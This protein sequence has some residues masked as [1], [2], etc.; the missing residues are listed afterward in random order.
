MK[1]ATRIIVPF[2]LII[3]VVISIGWYL[4]K[5]DPEFTKDFLLNQARL[6]EE[7][8]NHGLATWIYN[9]TYRQSNEDENVAIELAE[10][11]KSM[12]NYTKAEYTLSNAIADGGTAQLYIA[13]CNTYVEQDKLLDAVTMLDNIADPQIK[14]QLDEIRPSAPVAT[15]ESGYFNQYINV[16]IDATEGTVYI[17]TTGEYP[18]SKA[19]P[20][21]NDLTLS[22]G[23]T[24][25]YALCIGDNGLVSPLS[26]F[27]YTIAGVIE[28]VSLNDAAMDQLV[29]QQLGVNDEH[30]LYSNELWGI[31]SLD[32]TNEIK[33]L[34][35]LSLMP[36]LEQMTISS[37]SY[38]NLNSLSTLSS[39]HTLRIEGVTL[40][41]D[42]VKT[43]AAL[44]KLQT[45]SLPHCNLSSIADLSVATGLVSLDLSNNTLRDL[46]PLQNLTELKSLQISHNAVTQLSDIC[47]LSK[48]EELDVSYNSL[49]STADLAA[50]TGLKVLRLGHNTLTQLDGLEKLSGLSIIS[51]EGNKLTDINHLSTCSELTELNISDNQLSDISAVASMPKIQ[52]LDFS[53]NQVAQLPKF[54]SQD[55][56]STINGSS[57]LL[58]SLDELKGQTN[59]NYIIMDY[60]QSIT[61]VSPLRNCFNLVEVSV[62]ATGVRDVSAL[63]SMEIIVKYSPVSID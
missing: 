58:T 31:T 28:E 19:Q 61:S 47:T 5:Y 43:I 27:N 57:N 45:L 14:A 32:I 55:T 53:N 50:C 8:G 46:S 16:S 1:K 52:I 56:L 17:N 11:F 23:E 51:A 42:N 60:N 29:R 33:D 20:L 36:F 7:R 10:Q 15:P 37:G 13:L 48:L 6:A 24:N 59:L 9:L 21:S 18:S 26:I 39:L 35:D 34:S 30:T 49:S 3:A 2:L 40:T 54:A 12:G 62:Y 44:P 4:F 22:G 63:T 25:I 41:S 38:E